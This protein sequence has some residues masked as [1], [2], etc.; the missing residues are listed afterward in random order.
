[1]EDK[2]EG[3]Q[4]KPYQGR[5]FEAEEEVQTPKM[6]RVRKIVKLSCKQKC[7]KISMM[8]EK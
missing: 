5:T 7:N 4:A 2:W 1:M 3:G 8:A 6:E